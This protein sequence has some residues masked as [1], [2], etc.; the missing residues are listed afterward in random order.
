MT[1]Q[2]YSPLKTLRVQNFQSITDATVEL[3]AL[4]VLVGP[5]D[6]GKSAILRA[7]RA[8]VLNDGH[9]DDISHGEKQCQVT[10]TFEDGTEIVWW[11]DKKKGG[12]YGFRTADESQEF[13]KTGGAVPDVIAA[14]LGVGLIDVDATTELTPQLSD[15][16]DVP[17]ILWETGSKRARILGKATRLDTV[18]TAQM[19]C[20]KEFDK[21]HRDAEKASSELEEVEARLSALP[22]YEGLGARVKTTEE[23][24]QTIDDSLTLVRRA[25]E[26]ADQIE[27]VRSRAVAVDVAPLQ[28]RLADAAEAL[29]LAGR[30]QNI[31]RSLPDA[32]RTVGDLEGRINDNTAALESFIEQ[33]KTACEEAGVCTLCGGLLD[34]EE[35]K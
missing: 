1:E 15:Q 29:E 8:A 31:T 21:A 28:A 3:G 5:G 27:E 32:K 33:H 16:H 4:T 11:K 23:N 12:C 26:L 9:D 20:K 30:V 18:V 24:L 2:A 19:S 34:H 25:R 35:C 17:F 7:L 22:D 13:V 10:L 6:A 14:Y